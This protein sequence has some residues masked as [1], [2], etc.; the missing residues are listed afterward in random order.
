MCILG[1]FCCIKEC[2]KSIFATEK[3]K[4]QNFYYRILN[5]HSFLCLLFTNSI[6]VFFFMTMPKKRKTKA[7][8][9]WEDDYPKCYKFILKMIQ[10]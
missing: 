6:L 10:L 1:S 5:M 2:F 9:D 7:V 8:G 3:C 4:Q